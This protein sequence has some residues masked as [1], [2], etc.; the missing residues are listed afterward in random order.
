M[1]KQKDD[2]AESIRLMRADDFVENIRLMKVTPLPAAGAPKSRRRD[3]EFVMVSTSQI[4]RMREVN[5]T[6]YVFLRLLHLNFRA[7]GK[8]IRLTNAVLAP[9]G[10]HRNSKYKALRELETAGLIKVERSPKK[11][12]K[13]ILLDR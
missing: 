2:F 11:T 5:I 1:N 6:A 9:K 12:L 8:P 4:D 3:R 7:H 13:V 10:I